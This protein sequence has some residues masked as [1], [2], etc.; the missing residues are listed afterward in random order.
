MKIETT[1]SEFVE[2]NRD[3]TEY[4]SW[5]E[6]KGY[7]DK[8]KFL[9]FQARISKDRLHISAGY[10]TSNDHPGCW[11]SCSNFEFNKGIIPFK[12]L[13]EWTADINNALFDFGS[14]LEIADSI[15]SKMDEFIN[16]SQKIY[17]MYQEGVI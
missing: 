10:T 11:S 6:P 2:V 17:A 14:P 7:V 3:F 8:Q 16:K 13:A 15:I 12:D 9:H 1:L 5:D 4:D